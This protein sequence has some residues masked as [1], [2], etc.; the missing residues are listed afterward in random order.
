[1]VLAEPTAVSNIEIPDAIGWTPSGST[2]TTSVLVE[3]KVSRADFL[4]DRKKGTRTA[5]SSTQLGN[6]RWFMTTRRLLEREEIPEGWGLVEVTDQKAFVVKPAI[7]HRTKHEHA[8]SVLLIA[9]LGRVQEERF[10]EAFLCP[11][12]HT[13]AKHWAQII[14]R[15]AEGLE[16]TTVDE[17]IPH[18]P[19]DT[20]TDLYKRA[21]LFEALRSRVNALSH[22]VFSHRRRIM[23]GLELD[24]MPRLVANLKV[25]AQAVS[26]ATKS[27]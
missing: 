17:E 9:A 11:E 5:P 16:T 12:A 20:V 4:H 7:H 23:N 3:C 22:D 15:D 26:K 13:L 27:K 25:V 10:A 18:D 8:E 14:I 1:V 21:A 19:W 2:T 24:V 6:E